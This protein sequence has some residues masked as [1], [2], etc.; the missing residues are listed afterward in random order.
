VSKVEP[1]G[2]AKATGKV[3]VDMGIIS[4]NGEAVKG[5]MF[6]FCTRGCAIGSHACSLEASIEA[7]DQWHSS[8]VSIAFLS[9]PP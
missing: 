3:E 8:R 9:L 6:G 4:L 1:A 5:K 2:N 7:C